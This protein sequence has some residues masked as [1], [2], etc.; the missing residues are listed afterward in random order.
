MNEN[1]TRSSND[2][3]GGGK[4]ITLEVRLDGTMMHC[5]LAKTLLME[6]V[7]MGNVEQCNVVTERC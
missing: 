3:G 1:R 7:G 6:R 4:S 5:M 2:G